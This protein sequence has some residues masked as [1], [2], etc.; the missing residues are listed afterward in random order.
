MTQLEIVWLIAVGSKMNSKLKL[1]SVEMQADPHDDAD[2]RKAFLGR[3]E[4]LSRP[5]NVAAS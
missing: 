4:C 1:E 2:V 3:S 5:G